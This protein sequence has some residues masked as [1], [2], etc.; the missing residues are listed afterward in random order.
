METP[1]KQ[2]V[3]K[4]SDRV[5]RM[6]GEIA[7]KYDFMNHLLSMNT[8]RYWRWRTVRKVPPVDDRP[9]LDVCSGTGDLALAYFKAAKKRGFTCSVVA[10]D[11][12]PEML[13]IGR[14]KAAKANCSEEVVFH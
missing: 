8:D 1:A 13:A 6:F 9:I 5:R 10:A 14:E 11:F 3:D 12:C 2:T 7:G 4:S